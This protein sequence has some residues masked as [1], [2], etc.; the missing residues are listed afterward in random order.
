M[1]HLF[2]LFVGLI[3][4]AS[5]V[6]AQPIVEI[7][8]P[9]N[10]STVI[11]E[12]ISLKVN[13]NEEAVCYYELCGGSGNGGWCGRE[14]EMSLTGGTYH[15]DII[16]DLQ[17]TGDDGFYRVDLT[18]QNDNGEGE[19]SSTFYAD[20]KLKTAESGI[21]IRECGILDR[22]GA[23]YFL[24][25]D[26]TSN[27]NC[28]EIVQNE[29]TLD[30]KGHKIVGNN[31]Q[32]VAVI[33]KSDYATV[34]NGEISGFFVGVNSW[35]G[36]E[37]SKF[38]LLN[39]S[40]VEHGIYSTDNSNNTIIGNFVQNSG[41]GIYLDGSESS[42]VSNNEILNNT[43]VAGMR[44]EGC[45]NNQISR[46]YIKYNERNG[47]FISGN[48]SGNVFELNHISY[49]GD[50]MIMT[51]GPNNNYI[52][53]NYISHNNFG[54]D[55]VAIGL[56]FDSNENIISDN[57]I[58]FQEKG[59]WILESNNN[60]LQDNIIMLNNLPLLIHDSWGNI[61]SGNWV[62]ENDYS[63][64]L[65]SG[66]INNL[67]YNNY[68]NNEEDSRQGWSDLNFFNIESTSGRNV[69][70]GQ[71]LGGNYWANPD[72]TGFS[73]T[74]RDG[75]R[76]GFCDEYYVLGDDTIDYLPLSKFQLQ[77]FIPKSP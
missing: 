61:F 19:Q 39:I 18:C 8:N 31:G 65:S 76:D 25:R 40:N 27:G 51:S 6:S 17:N 1:G 20:I 29:I 45:K 9:Q 66:A 43:G 77:T 36:V 59:V 46:N 60:S 24:T 56:Y 42:L 47:I 3:L 69:I 48:S 16:T 28:F 38:E 14:N 37:N 70:G 68:F 21:P 34:K 35:P 22:P 26:L 50:G 33:A 54:V 71:V 53:R 64:A 5:S 2:M 74:C 55:N 58:E 41:V 30:L 52:R 11:S 23:R 75:D 7:L 57:D 13:T 12:S 49:N 15:Q 32:G 72:G 73:E 62:E 10:G 4:L 67:I 44:C 63:F